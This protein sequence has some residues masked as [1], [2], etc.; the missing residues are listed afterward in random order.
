[1]NEFLFKQLDK[2]DF[3]FIEISLFYSTINRNVKKFA[4]SVLP[5]TRSI[6]EP[7]ALLHWAHCMVNLLGIA[8]WYPS[9]REKL[10]LK[11]LHT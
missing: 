9:C 8:A 3:T 5:D 11:W 7:G 2:F 10:L 1:M 6:T 4:I